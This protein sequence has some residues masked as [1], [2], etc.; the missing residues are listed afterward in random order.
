MAKKKMSDEQIERICERTFPLVD[1]LLNALF[2]LVLAAVIYF[3]WGLFFEN[4]PP[5]YWKMFGSIFL[6]LVV[7]C[8]LFPA[9]VTRMR[10]K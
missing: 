8:D 10:S 2:S 1:K 4:A 9:L 7:V 3:A 6:L 5:A